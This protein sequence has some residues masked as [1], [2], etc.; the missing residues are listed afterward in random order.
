MMSNQVSQLIRSG[1]I[2]QNTEIFGSHEQMLRS[3]IH[4]EIRETFETNQKK[5]SRLQIRELKHRRF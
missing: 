5:G 4:A 3:A 1:S 2:N